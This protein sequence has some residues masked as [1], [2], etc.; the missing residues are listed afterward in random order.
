MPAFRRQYGG[1]SSTGEVQLARSPLIYFGMKLNVNSLFRREQVREKACDWLR[2]CAKKQYS[3]ASLTKCLKSTDKIWE[4]RFDCT[5]WMVDLVQ[6]VSDEEETSQRQSKLLI[7]IKML[8]YPRDND[9]LD[10]GT[11]HLTGSHLINHVPLPWRTSDY[12]HREQVRRAALSSY[13][14]TWK[15]PGDE[16]KETVKYSAIYYTIPSQRA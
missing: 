1:V 12:I 5:I 14:S 11:S 3:W 7:R 2:E 16:R 10:M 4:H 15:L 13:L 9:V 6:G 8:P